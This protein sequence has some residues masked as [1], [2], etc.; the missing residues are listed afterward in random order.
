M[1]MDD[2]STASRLV[3]ELMLVS[4]MVGGTGAEAFAAALAEAGAAAE[5]LAGPDPESGY[6]LAVLLGAPDPD[7]A[8]DMHG[9]VQS[10]TQA[11]ERLLL[12]PVPSD[13]D[14]GGRSS[15]P[16]P[17]LTRW[18]E[19]FAELGYQPVVDFDAGFVAAGAF[20]VDRGATAAESELAAFADRLQSVPA[21]AP[22]AAP[23]QADFALQAE[24]AALRDRLPQLEAQVDHLVYESAEAK[25]ALQEA[26]SRNAGWDGLRGWVNAA[27]RDRARDTLAAL[28]HDLPILKILRGPDAPPIALSLPRQHPAGG[29]LSRLFGS[30]AAAPGP[31]PVELE[32]TA[33]VRASRYFDPAWYI[34]STPELCAGECIDPVFHYVFVGSV[35]RA[36]P[37]PWFDTGAYLAANPAAAESGMSALAHALRSG[38]PEV[39]QEISA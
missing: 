24:L 8:S 4:V 3:N 16:L 5:A 9:L 27:V 23:P 25:A 34:A 38:A 15:P 10:L 35:R 6:D 31:A 11:S 18:F 22:L 30:S 14:D 2:P 13:G 37:G 7:A 29:W 19:I 1:L 33:L 12:V 28:R 32:E 36:D 21:A 39:Q 20:L 17:G 26:Q